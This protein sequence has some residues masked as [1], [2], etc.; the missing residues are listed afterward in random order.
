MKSYYSILGVD[1]DANGSQIKKRYRK[2][3]VKYHPDKNP[4][5]KGA[6]ER[7]REVTEVYEV[8]KDEKKRKKYDIEHGFILSKK[9][10][11]DV[12]VETTKDVYDKQTKTG[13]ASVVID[14]NGEVYVDISK[15]SKDSGI[16]VDYFRGFFSKG[17]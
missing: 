9:K 10:R 14:P 13:G 3:A 12:E 16:N 1:S 2:L 5:D 7:F 8:L 4:G 15:I 11:V 17:E 6:E